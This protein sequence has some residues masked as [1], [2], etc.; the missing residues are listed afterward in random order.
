MPRERRSSQVRVEGRSYE[1]LALDH[2]L[3]FTPPLA[4][5]SANPGTFE[6]W[7]RLLQYTFEFPPPESF[8]TLA[9]LLSPDEMLATERFCMA[10]G[11]LAE[12]SVWTAN[13]SVRIRVADDQSSETVDA[14]FPPNEITRGFSA[15]FR[16][17]YSNEE[18]ASFQAMQRILRAANQTANDEHHQ[19]R[20]DQLTHWGRAHG[21]LRGFPLKVLVGKRLRAEGRWPGPI[22]GEDDESPEV[23]IKRY[24]YGDYIHW[25]ESAGQL[26]I[27]SA[28]PFDS[29]W[30]RMRFLE[31]VG[32]LAHLYM[33]F[34]LLV[35]AAMG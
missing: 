14:K 32:G 7:W 6:F 15:L 34:S 25:G 29:A 16:Q 11:E 18:P 10:A 20:L 33:G 8:P 22:P 2:P 13:S 27:W 30:Q 12:S 1:A 5:R 21:R 19:T 17:F 3:T 23:I 26:K 24:N 9:G 35:T 31:A 4:E 28:D